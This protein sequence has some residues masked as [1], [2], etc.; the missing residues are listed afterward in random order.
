MKQQELQ[1]MYGATPDSFKMAV[2][3][4]LH[5]VQKDHAAHRRPLRFAALAA[6]LLVMMGAAY[7]AFPSQVAAFFGRIYGQKTES[8]LQEGNADANVKTL[9]LGGAIFTLEEVV[10]RNHGLYGIGT[11]RLPEGS[12]DVLVAEDQQLDE[13]FG[14]DIHGA[15]GQP[16]T[17]PEHTPTLLE[18][19]KAQGGRLL[20]AT[21]RL[22][23]VG[24]D[25]GEMLMPD[26]VG[27]NAIPQ[28]DGSLRVT[29]EVE[30]G[31]SIEPGDTYQLALW[32]SVRELSE[33]GSIKK[34]GQAQQTWEVSLAPKPIRP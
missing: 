17:A 29:F 10:Q 3:R 24:A 1:T 21:L 19:A 33:D 27:Y 32:A 13:P 34:S 18:K 28:R 5:A 2:Q 23:K 6:A 11:V 12:A 25:G 20:L 16:E 15:G 22:D 9:H 14:Y 7:A 26:C 8:W 4:G 30:D 31:V